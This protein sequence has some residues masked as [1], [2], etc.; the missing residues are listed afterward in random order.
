V[1]VDAVGVGFRRLVPY[2]AR[3]GRRAVVAADLAR[4]H[5]PT[6]GVVEL[7]HRLFWQPDRHVN[8]DNPALLAWMYETVLRE[9]ATVEELH[10]WLDGPTLIRLW[11]DI[12]VP[13]G[14]RQA[15][16]E[17]HPVLR[18]ATAA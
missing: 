15:W 13:R 12:V 1:D 7:P 14:V 18:R 2:E 10:T 6:S 3:P 4:L 16:E 17:R 11:P 8:L 9:A 5:G